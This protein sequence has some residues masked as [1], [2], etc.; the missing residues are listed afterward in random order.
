MKVQDIQKDIYKKDL[1]DPFINSYP[2]Y[3][4]SIAEEPK[5]EIKYEAQAEYQP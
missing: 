4:N 1:Y 3:P 2:S 5:G